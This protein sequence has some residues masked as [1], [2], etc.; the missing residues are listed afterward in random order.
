M[1]L[2][3][4]EDV[5]LVRRRAREEAQRIG[6]SL[7]DTTKLVT[8]ASELARNA[9]EHGGGGWAEFEQLVLR[10]RKG[11]RITFSDEGPGIPDIE[12]A[13]SNGFTTGRGLGLGLGGSKRLVNEFELDSEPGRGTTVRITRWK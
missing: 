2:E 4:D 1:S 11:V 13:L 7:T 9:I 6:L 5:V 8:A 3:S 10:G 12:R